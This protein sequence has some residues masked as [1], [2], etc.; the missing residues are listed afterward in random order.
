MRIFPQFYSPLVG[1]RMVV[2]LALLGTSLVRAEQVVCHYSYGGETK[3]LVARPVAS[4][5]A[6]T[7]VQV[8]S[9]FRL[10]IVFQDR[11]AD[12]ASVKVYTYAE[13][14]GSQVLIHQAIFR[15][16]H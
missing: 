3:Q 6:V 14:N 7:G 13:R 2:V 12:I 1:R 9:Y 16:R 11:P 5:Y 15:T 8:G 10:R 4:P